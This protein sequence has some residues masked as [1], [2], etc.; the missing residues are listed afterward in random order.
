M[1]TLASALAPHLGRF[2]GRPRV[3]AD[4]NVPAGIVTFMR[5]RLR[6]D[7][8]FVLEH[9]DLRRASDG[10]HFRRA[11]ELRRTLITL[12][13]DY[14]DETRFPAAASGGVIVITAPGERGLRTVLRQID[15]RIFRSRPASKEAVPAAPVD[16]PAS[17]LP[18][19]GRT[20]HAHP[21]W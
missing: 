3:Y 17:V 15:R 2:G 6:W 5:Q 8:L 10:E 19:R 21:G 20:M 1:S 16:E 12:D 9:D 13:R 7:V 18:L 14:F 4:A 11:R